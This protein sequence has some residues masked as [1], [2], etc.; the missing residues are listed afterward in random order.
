LIGRA[1]A[2]WQSPR[3]GDRYVMRGPRAARTSICEAACIKRVMLLT[4]VSRSDAPNEPA[5]A[6]KLVREPRRPF[7]FR[8]CRREQPN[9]QLS[10]TDLR[11]QAGAQCPIDG[12]SDISINI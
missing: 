2:Q 9:R 8:P 10:R 4:V 11:E 3:S 1:S 7:G 5:A 6:L 12:G